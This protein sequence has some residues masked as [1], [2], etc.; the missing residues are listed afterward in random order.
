MKVPLQVKGTTAKPEFLPDVG[1]VAA[2]MLKNQ[3]SC[4]GG[5]GGLANTAE[6]LAGGN[7]GTADA[8]NQL[9]GL[10]NKKKKP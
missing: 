8:I 7:K 9:G 1:G 2:G 10:L 3:L 6:G 4:A 5:A